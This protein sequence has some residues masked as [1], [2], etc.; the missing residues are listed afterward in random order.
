MQEFSP[1]LTLL[2]LVLFR[3]GVVVELR[4]LVCKF[5]LSSLPPKK[6]EGP[7]YFECCTVEGG[8]MLDKCVG[9]G[10]RRRICAQWIQAV[11]PFSFFTW[12]IMWFVFVTLKSP[13][14]GICD[15]WATVDFGRWSKTLS[16]TCIESLL[17]RW[18]RLASSL[19]SASSLA[20]AT[21]WCTC[22]RRAFICMFFFNE[23]VNRERSM[24]FWLLWSVTTHNEKNFI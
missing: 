8:V 11:S 10:A 12:H 3:L 7:G 20:R 15:D 23:I 17:V 19:W 13:T 1:A 6:M 24:A 2:A 16:P 5:L 21:R 14:Q 9:Y 22:L 4:Y 18:F